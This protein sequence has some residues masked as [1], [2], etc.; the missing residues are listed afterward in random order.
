MGPEANVLSAAHLE[1][2][3]S[4]RPPTTVL[5]VEAGVGDAVGAAAGPRGRGS[6]IEDPVRVVIAVDR[7][8]LEVDALSA[9]AARVADPRVRRT[10]SRGISRS[11]RR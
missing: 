5:G 8:R 7:I 6:E 10:R 11:G 4:L 3:R 9:L 1:G 2:E